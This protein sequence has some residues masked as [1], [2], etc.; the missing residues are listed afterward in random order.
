MIRTAVRTVI[1]AGVVGAVAVGGVAIG[2]QLQQQ[3]AAPA[4]QP[5][6]QTVE[7]TTAPQ[8]VEPGTVLEAKPQTDT[9]VASDSQT[10]DPAPAASVGQ[11]TSTTAGTATTQEQTVTSEP[12]QQASSQPTAEASPTAEQTTA[13]ETTAPAAPQP[14]YSELPTPSPG[15][16]NQGP[17]PGQPGTQAD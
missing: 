1:T 10:T 6:S 8:P 13:A 15:P 7:A 12:T 5:V 4:Q 3:P 14:A 17:I 11:D 2:Q 16:H 9:Q